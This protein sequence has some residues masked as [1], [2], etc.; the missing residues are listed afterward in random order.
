MNKAFLFFLILITSAIS[1]V[2]GA[3]HTKTLYSNIIAEK[4]EA[5]QLQ[6]L[7]LYQLLLQTLDNGDIPTARDKILSAMNSVVYHAD[8]LQQYS[9]K[10]AEA[11]EIYKI[12]H[13]YRESNKDMY[14]AKNDI[15]AEVSNI[16][17][18][19]SSLQCN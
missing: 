16:I 18:K 4:D 6:Q 15:D 17:E 2:S 3:H 13:T 12:I 7:A 8:P 10:N 5:I 11:C 1:A 14:E 9:Y 19:W